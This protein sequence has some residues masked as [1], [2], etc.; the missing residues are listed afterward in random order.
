MDIIAERFEGN[1]NKELYNSYIFPKHLV[2]KI[3]QLD[4]VL[5]RNFI[6]NEKFEVLRNKTTDLSRKNRRLY[7]LLAKQ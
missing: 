7:I 3:S 2:E 4:R 1:G 6:S 5:D